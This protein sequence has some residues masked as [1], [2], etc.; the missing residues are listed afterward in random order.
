MTGTTINLKEQLVQEI[1][2]ITESLLSQLLD[3]ALFIKARCRED[4][5]SKMERANIT[6]AKLDYEA[7]DYITFEE[8][9][10]NQQ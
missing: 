4:E 5:I 1:D 9:E 7:G 10:A 3:F 6:A 8:Y 2:Q